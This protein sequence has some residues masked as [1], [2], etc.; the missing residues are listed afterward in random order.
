MVVHACSD[1]FALHMTLCPWLSLHVLIS[2][3]QNLDKFGQFYSLYCRLH[4]LSMDCQLHSACCAIQLKCMLKLQLHPIQ[5]HSQRRYLQ[6]SNV[7]LSVVKT[8]QSRVGGQLLLDPTSD[9]SYHEDGTVLMAM[10]PTANLVSG[11]M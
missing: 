7:R 2:C 8:L 11:T 3:I 5:G 9:E 6:L 1:S 10:M 4:Y